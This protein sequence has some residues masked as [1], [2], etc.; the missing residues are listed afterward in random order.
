MAILDPAYVSLDND[1]FKQFY[2]YMEITFDLTL[3]LLVIKKASV[4]QG[5]SSFLS[6]IK[7][8]SIIGLGKYRH[9]LSE[10]YKINHKKNLIF[11]HS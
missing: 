3:V 6:T 2:K 10:M 11:S 7:L 4:A 5:L 9:F 1:L 8:S